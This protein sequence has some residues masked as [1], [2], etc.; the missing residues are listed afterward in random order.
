MDVG[1][2]LTLVLKESVRHLYI[3]TLCPIPVQVETCD[4][5]CR[6]AFDVDCD[7]GGPG[8]DWSLC[9]YGTDCRDCCSK[10]QSRDECANF[11]I[12]VILFSHL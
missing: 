7:D 11:V 4:N 6:Y 2:G 3:L 8:S 5:T 12:G 9:D 10:V 1:V